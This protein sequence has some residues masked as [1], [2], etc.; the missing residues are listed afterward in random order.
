MSHN[1]NKHINYGISLL[2]IVSMLMVVMLHVLGQGGILASS[3]G[4]NNKVAWWLEIM[5]IGA[6]NCFG[7][8][9]GYLMVSK[10]F[11]F[12]KLANIWFQV[13]F[14]SFG[15]SLL[16]YILG[17]G[18]MSLTGLYKFILPV[19]TGQYWYVTAY[20]VTFMLIPV[21]NL[22]LNTFDQK[23]LAKQLLVFFVLFS[24]L[25]IFPRFN[26]F[27]LSAGYSWMWLSYL[28][29]LGGYYRKYYSE[30]GRKL[31]FPLLIYLLCVSLTFIFKFYIS[32]ILKYVSWSALFEYIAPTTLIGS[33]ALLSY[34][35]NFA[36]NRKFL[37]KSILLLSNLSFGVYLFH[38]NPIVWDNFMMGAFSHYSSYNLSFFLISIFASVLAIYFVG[39]SIDFIR[40][41]LFQALEVEKLSISVGDKL[42][43]V[44][45]I[46]I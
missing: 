7:L 24:V 46:L 16:Y 30:F 36:V 3:Q 41:K 13:I 25:S 37:R 45:S 15:I 38:V 19:T 5:S 17:N 39:I 11:N 8:V 18:S 27:N 31:R 2:K 4:L 29:M 35:D 14:Y 43:L 6:V 34:F 40:L 21:L 1:E 10:K 42:D 22:A 20:F 9:T 23:F 12:A 44:S 33:V 32:S 26:G 28:Y